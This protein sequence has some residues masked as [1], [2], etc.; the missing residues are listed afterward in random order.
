VKLV[1]I[2]ASQFDQVGES[3]PHS[4]EAY[5]IFLDTNPEPA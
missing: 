1:V 5:V 3:F 2:V 4:H